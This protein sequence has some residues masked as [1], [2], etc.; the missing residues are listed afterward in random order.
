MEWLK[1]CSRLVILGIGN[2]LRGDDSVGLKIAW[3]LRGKLPKNVKI[4][5]GGVTPENF[6]GK[7]RYIKP[8]HVLLI[9]AAHFG[10][11]PGEI[12]LIYPEEISGV[13][14]STHVIPLYILAD[15][16]HEEMGA[17]VILLG[18]EPKDLSLGA[19]I[20]PEIRE[21]IERSV[22]LI[23]DVIRSLRIN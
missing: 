23:I 12:K 7:I 14:I 18:I 8:S 1:D 13:A 2:P 4:I 5:R 22:E 17:K 15:L 10:G 16:I 9:D 21:A 19:K 20:S 3:R 11:K 6:I